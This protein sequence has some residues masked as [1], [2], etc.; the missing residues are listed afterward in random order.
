[1]FP[2]N[3]AMHAAVVGTGTCYIST[4]KPVVKWH[5]IS[6]VIV[7]SFCHTWKDLRNLWQIPELNRD[8][9]CP[10]GAVF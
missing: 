1:M 4:A 6:I 3:P 5:E 8:R 9:H 10:L 2:N 7:V